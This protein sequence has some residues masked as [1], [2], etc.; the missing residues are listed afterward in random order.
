ME[1]RERAGCRP[2][3]EPLEVAHPTLDLAQGRLGAAHVAREDGREEGDPEPSKL[4]V[5]RTPAPELDRP[6]V[7]PGLLR[8][9]AGRPPG[10]ASMVLL[11]EPASLA[12]P[13]DAPLPCLGL[14]SGRSFLL[15]RAAVRAP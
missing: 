13:R 6:G 10:G 8:H 11:R 12:R 4:L 5:R 1:V 2:L 15:S 3:A 14:G 9:R 7:P